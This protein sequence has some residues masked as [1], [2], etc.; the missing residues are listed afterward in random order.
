MTRARLFVST[1][2][3]ALLALA[4]SA[5]DAAAQGMKSLAGS[6][7]IVSS[8]GTV[9]GKRVETYGE[10]PKGMLILS[11]NGQYQ[12]SIL[13]NDLPKFV[14]NAR[15]KGTPEE[16]KAVVGGSINHFGR[17]SVDEKEKT[18]TFNIDGST[19]PNW[20][21]TTQKRPYTLKGGTLTYQVLSSSG[22]TGSGEVVWQ[23]IK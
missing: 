2:S 15:V 18:I 21:G 3:S 22:G 19:F 5:S 9:D 8:A 10:K 12:L 11:G 14:S 1:A 6:Y 23:R 7:S 20:A 17:Y 13:R 4:I 16:N